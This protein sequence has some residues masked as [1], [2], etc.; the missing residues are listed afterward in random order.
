LLS[1]QKPEALQ[2]RM[3]TALREIDPSQQPRPHFD[4]TGSAL[5]TWEPMDVEHEYRSD[6]SYQQIS[7]GNSVRS[8]Q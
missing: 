4:A 6:F 3:A 5:L 7:T 8:R 1:L 2:V